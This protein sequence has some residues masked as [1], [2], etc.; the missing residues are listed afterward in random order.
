[1][2]EFLACVMERTRAAARLREALAWHMP[3]GEEAW[4]WRRAANAPYVR[5]GVLGRAALAFLMEGAA[6][7][8]TRALQEA[9]AAELRGVARTLAAI[10]E[11]AWHARL[12]RYGRHEGPA[13]AE[14]RALLQQDT[15]YAWR[16]LAEAS[17]DLSALWDAVLGGDLEAA[18]AHVVREDPDA[19]W[20]AYWQWMLAAGLGGQDPELDARIADLPRAPPF[21]TPAAMQSCDRM[22]QRA[23]RP[24]QDDWTPFHTDRARRALIATDTLV[25]PT[26]EVAERWRRI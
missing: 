19:F 1:M 23:V 4:L 11:E 7:K 17:A 21:R 3:S 6:A 2:A 15:H 20:G 13:P 5:R 22:L 9:Y 24:L 18:M 12:E 10:R 25:E 16:D 8:R 26:P 14:I